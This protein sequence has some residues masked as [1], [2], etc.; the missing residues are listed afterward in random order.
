MFHGSL[1]LC[2]DQIVFTAVCKRLCL[3]SAMFFKRNA[4]RLTAVSELL[5]A[6]GLAIEDDNPFWITAERYITDAVAQHNAVDI[7]IPL[8]DEDPPTSIDKEIACRFLEAFCPGPGQSDL[9]CFLLASRSTSRSKLAESL[10][11]TE[12]RRTI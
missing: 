9:I 11:P 5:R 4:F 7:S 10:H 1:R 8:V 12:C 6:L 3:T 2:L